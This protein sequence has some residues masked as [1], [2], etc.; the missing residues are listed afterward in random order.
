MKYCFATQLEAMRAAHGRAPMP[1]VKWRKEQLT[2]L[3]RLLAENEQQLY[4]ALKADL[5][6]SKSEAF[7]TEL[8]LIYSQ[9]DTA[10]RSLKSWMRPKRAR[11]GLQNWPATAQLIPQ[12]VGVV[13]IIAPWN[14]PVMLALA[15]LVGALAAG[16]RAVIKPSEVTEHTSALLAELIGRYFESEVVQVIEGGVAETTELL[17]HPYGHI[18]FTG[19]GD[20]GKI[21]M[22]AAADTLTPVTLE[23]GGKS[24]CIL[25]NN[26][27]ME[28]A[29][30]RIAWGKSL[31]AGQTCVAPDY[32]LALPGTS[33]AFKLGFAKNIKAF[34]GDDPQKS[35]DLPRIVN[36][37]HFERLRS[38][39]TKDHVAYGG[40]YDVQDR[41][42]QP[43]L[44]HHLP[45]EHPALRD[46]IFGPILPIIEVP[47]LDAAIRYINQ[48]PKPL[49][50][51]GF[52]TNAVEQQRITDETS[53]GSVV[54]NDVVIQ[55]G[56]HSLPFG[57]VGAS[58][59]GRSH[60]KAAFD[61]F[62]HMKPVLNKALRGE[63]KLRYAP[64]T[65]GKLK[66]VRRFMKG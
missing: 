10:Q 42:I 1:D 56:T 46:E 60:G 15:P 9:I 54:F 52:T 31:N 17:R 7:M 28:I 25:T 50:L 33:E 45:D 53:S 20:V 40:A 43:T 48:R 51:Y 34:F 24:P 22:R 21:V 41:Y 63:V 38:Q 18:F 30:R 27:D 35:P 6:K 49:A 57:G 39:L 66:T 55:F 26:T 13:L 8:G 14:Y 61:T 37:R 19:G 5:G 36:A 62:S 65:K 2:T 12:P 3:R 59:M 11:A 47:D 64:F 23:L 29:A 4:G 58:G 32:I 44:L 16:N